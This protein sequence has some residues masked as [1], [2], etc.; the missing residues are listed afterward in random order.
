MYNAN[1]TVLY[2]CALSDSTYTEKATCKQACGTKVVKDQLTV[3][4]CC[5]MTGGKHR[6]HIIRLSEKP[7]Y[8]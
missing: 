4:I 1:K 6:L 7:Q 8:F 3:L 5:S 2:F